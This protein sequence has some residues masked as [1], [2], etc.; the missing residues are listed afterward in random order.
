MKLG[1]A[2]FQQVLMAAPWTLDLVFRASFYA[3]Y[4]LL[5]LQVFLRGMLQ[6]EDEGASSRTLTG[7]CLP[8]MM[9]LLKDE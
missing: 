1:A 4:W 2:N 5:L 3:D 9:D 7:I 8:L 6:E